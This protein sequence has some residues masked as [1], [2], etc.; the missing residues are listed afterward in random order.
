MADNAMIPYRMR[1]GALKT[2]ISTSEPTVDS[3]R[4]F[5]IFVI[6]ENPYDVPIK[7]YS[8]QTHLPV[9]LLDSAWLQKYL[10]AQASEYEGRLNKLEGLDKYKAQFKFFL[11]QVKQWLIPP[12]G[13]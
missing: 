3:L 2:R 1:R 8:A 10:T 11:K 12:Q 13:S 7:I 9:E 4:D 6:I 5:S